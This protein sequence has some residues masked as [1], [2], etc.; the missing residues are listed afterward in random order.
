[1]EWIRTLGSFEWVLIILFIVLYAAY[2]W[3]VVNIAKALQT[4]FSGVYIKIIL[5]TL[6]FSLL[7]MAIL[8][9]SFGQ[10]TREVKAVGKDIFIA[11]D[12]SE[13]MNAHDIQPT[14]LER[15]KFELKKI[16][17]A[18]SS[19]RIGLIIFSS[20]A[21]MQ[22]P[23]TFDQ[24]ALNMFV[25]ILHTGLVP[26]AGTD[27]GPPL[28]M[29]LDKLNDEE[30]TVTQQKSKIIVLIS[31]G[32][33]FGEETGEVVEDIVNNDIRLFALGVGTEQGSRIRTSKGFKMDKSGKEVITRLDS[34]S[35]KQIAGDTDGEYFEINESNN[36]V[37]R[38]INNINNIEGEVRDVREMDVTT[39]KYFYFLAAALLLIFIDTMTSVKVIRI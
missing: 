24:N 6:Y 35:L 39:D 12:L 8:G 29:A 14:R 2:I 22:C 7:M 38:L 13:S 27:F 5:R 37:S 9:P 23:L 34:R 16:V 33:D 3:R 31:D 30:G 19:D 17:E 11:V 36:D 28:S 15:I 18:F 32:E 10:S 4:R 21:F 20:E 1:M 26:N 25:E